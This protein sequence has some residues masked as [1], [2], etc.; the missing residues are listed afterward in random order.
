MFR[1]D[2]AVLAEFPTIRAGV[3]HASGLVNGSSPA[4]LRDQYEIEQ[5][6]VAARLASTAIGD[7]P[8]IAA[9]RRVFTRFGAKPTQ[10]RCAAEALLRRLAKHGDIPAI[11]TLV[12]IGNLVSIRY[13]MPVAVV[14]LAGITGMTTVQFAAG[15]EVFTDLGSSASVH[16]EPGEVIFAD[17]ARRVSAR[18]W[19]WRQSAQSATSDATVEA[20]IIVEGHHDA[21]APDVKAATDDITTLLHTYQ[22]GCQVRLLDT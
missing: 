13:A 20:L 17:E 22:P 8:S 4:P 15:D 6:V 2:D 3:V 14:D 9:W 18:R 1:Y 11:S 5:Q 19:C 7:L 12:D 21:A 16:P 10:Y